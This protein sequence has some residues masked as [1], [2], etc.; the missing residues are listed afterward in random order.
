M[1]LDMAL[2]LLP[3]TTR[4]RILITS[5]TIWETFS[6]TDTLV[7][8]RHT[9]EMGYLQNC[10]TKVSNGPQLGWKCKE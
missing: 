6:L 4:R 3:F 1:G 8:A 5:A 7:C 9:Y 2:L 10:L